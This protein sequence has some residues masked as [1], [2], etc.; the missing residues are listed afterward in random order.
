MVFV[1]VNRIRLFG[2]V[3]KENKSNMIEGFKS[4]QNV[5]ENKKG[6]RRRQYER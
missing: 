3:D 2:K 6:F 5:W 1:S 4:L